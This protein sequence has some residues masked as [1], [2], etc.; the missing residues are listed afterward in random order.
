MSRLHNGQG[1][2]RDEAT[3]PLLEEVNMTIP[4]AAS[5]NDQMY[6][7]Y[8]RT[9][10]QGDP[11]MTRAGEVRTV[12]DYEHRYGQIPTASANQLENPIQQY[13]AS[14]VSNIETPNARPLE[15]LAAVDFYTTLGTGSI[16]GILYPGTPLDVGFTENNPTSA[17]RVPPESD[18]PAW[19]ILPRA[20]T[21][22]QKDNANRASAVLEFLQVDATLEDSEI[23]IYP[24][25]GNPVTMIAKTYANY[26]NSN[27]NEFLINDFIEDTFT[28]PGATNVPAGGFVN[29]VFTFDGV[30]LEDIILVNSDEFLVWDADPANQLV[31]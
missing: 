20:F 13:D 3:Q 6:L 8:N 27:Q 22:G 28:I 15:V 19:R 21:E 5:L 31:I 7:G 23:K 17:S 4:S 1:T 25:E 18:T 26:D 12:S 29:F 14:G 16:G 24:V 10:Y 9:V 11:F 2:L 30:N